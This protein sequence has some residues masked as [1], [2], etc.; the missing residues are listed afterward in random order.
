MD[1]LARVGVPSVFPRLG[2]INVVHNST[3]EHV[4]AFCSG[5]VTGLL[6]VPR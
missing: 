5:A 1:A 2:A 3:L 6:P 4:I